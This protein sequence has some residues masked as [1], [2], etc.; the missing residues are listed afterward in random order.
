MKSI[1]LLGLVSGE[2]QEKIIERYFIDTGLGEAVLEKDNDQSDRLHA[3]FGD[4]G[5]HH[6]TKMDK[7]DLIGTD[8]EK[9]KQTYIPHTKSVFNELKKTSQANMKKIRPTDDEVVPKRPQ[10]D[11]RDKILQEARDSEFKAPDLSKLDFGKAFS[12]VMT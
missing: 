8:L 4:L 2:E 5:V 7:S 3:L 9:L 10:D 1:I 11:A 12:N 6:P